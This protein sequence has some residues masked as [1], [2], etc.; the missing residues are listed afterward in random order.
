MPFPSQGDPSNPGVEPRSSTLQADSLPYGAT[1]EAHR[2]GKVSFFYRLGDQVRS[3]ERYLMPDWRSIGIPHCISQTSDSNQY[4]QGQ[5]DLSSDG[6][7][8]VNACAS[9]SHLEC[10]IPDADA[11]DCQP[12][13]K[14]QFTLVIPHAA[15]AE[16][17]SMPVSCLVLEPD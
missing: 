14:P 16:L 13:Q 11:P 6:D 1:K 7:T 15:I 3:M 8:Q 12:V 5:G 17:F 9:R 4:S 10:D 2:P